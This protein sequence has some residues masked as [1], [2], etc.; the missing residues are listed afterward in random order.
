MVKSEELNLMWDKLVNLAKYYKIELNPFSKKSNLKK[1][2]H[3][4]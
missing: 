4:L 2:Y 3:M 1:Q